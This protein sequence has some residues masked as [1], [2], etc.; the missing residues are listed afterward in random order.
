MTKK[1]LDGYTLRWCLRILRDSEHC[2]LETAD[3]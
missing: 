2:C 1:K 3:M